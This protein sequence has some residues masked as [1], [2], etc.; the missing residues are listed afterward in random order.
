M[1]KIITISGYPKHGKSEL[2][3]AISE[4]TGRQAGECS[5][6]IY[7][8]EADR[9]G[10]PVAKLRAMP[11]DK[12][13]DDLVR[14]GDKACEADIAVFPKSLC[15]RGARIIVGIRRR[16]EFI[17]FRESLDPEDQFLSIWISR[18]VELIEDNTEDFSDICDI[19]WNNQDS[20]AYMKDLV[21]QL[22]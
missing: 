9:R 7:Q 16:E 12:I 6:I 13:R 11:K 21:R 17:T 15:L 5:D 14:T 22:F 1:E 8:I 20:I 19:W 4:W 2:G 18:D 10:I 3:D